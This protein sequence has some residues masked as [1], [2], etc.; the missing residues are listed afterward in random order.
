VRRL[1]LAGTALA[2]V[3]GAGYAVLRTPTVAAGSV[4]AADTNA[5]DTGAAVETSRAPAPDAVDESLRVE[6]LPAQ[7]AVTLGRP[8]V[9]PPRRIG[10]GTPPYRRRLT[11]GPGVSLGEL[12]TVTVAPAAA[13]TSGP[14]TLVVTDA[15]GLSASTQM[16]VVASPPLRLVD[17]PRETATVGRPYRVAFAAKGGRPPYAW[18]FSGQAPEGLGFGNGALSGVPSAVGTSPGMV[19]TVT[20]ADGRQAYSGSFAVEVS[21][22]LSLQALP[23]LVEAVSGHAVS[24]PP[25]AVS[26]GAEPYV[27]TLAGAG[28]SLGP[29]GSINVVPG[30][31]G[32]VVDLVLTVR[33]A[34]GRS[35]ETRTRIESVEPLRM[36]GYAGAVLPRG[37]EARVAGVP[38]TG[39]RGAVRRLLVSDAGGSPVPPP[40]G[41]SFS[42][43]DGS[44]YGIAGDAGEHGPYRMRAVDGR[45]SAVDGLPFTIRVVEPRDAQPSTRREVSVDGVRAC[46]SSGLADCQRAGD[47]RTVEVRYPELVRVNE[48]AF[49]CDYAAPPAGVWEINDGRRWAA[50]EVTGGSPCSALIPA[51]AVTAVRFTRVEG[52]FTRLWAPRAT[53]AP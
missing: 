39:G 32:G 26:G 50:A 4:A 3:S 29:D 27:R 35:A 34:R 38:V 9:L 8:L 25:P 11:G 6:T 49:G 30:P 24:L 51:T 40:R 42:A 33:D 1:L 2:F 46:S 37:I 14:F 48:L 15:N 19:V 45:G 28:A 12:G 20:D 13:G 31:S 23:P 10:N 5:A 41:L 7:V 47:F 18:S 43:D 22:A 52:S 53:Y 44:L 21:E 17:P 36:G 16:F